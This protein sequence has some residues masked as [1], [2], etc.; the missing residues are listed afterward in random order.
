MAQSKLDLGSTALLLSDLQNDFIHPD[1][2]YGRAGLG[3]PEIARWGMGE[4]DM[5]ELAQL[6]ARALAGNEEPETVATD[7]TA[8]RA[9]FDRLRFVD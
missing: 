9:R 5:P 2:A 4:A 8:F 1:G 6:I 3:T 7:V